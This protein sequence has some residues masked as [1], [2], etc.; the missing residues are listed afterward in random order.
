MTA[1]ADPLTISSNWIQNI[2]IILSFWCLRAE[3]RETSQ[4]ERFTQVDHNSNRWVKLGA[5]AVLLIFYT[6]CE[7]GVV[8]N[9]KRFLH[10]HICCCLI[11][12]TIET[13]IMCNVSHALLLWNDIDMTRQKIKDDNFI[14]F[15]YQKDRFDYNTKVT[16]LCTIWSSLYMCY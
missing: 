2:E 12:E 16:F 9:I 1:I 3:T 10:M 8:Y 5:I 6:R 7:S 14:F 11:C 13:I 15:P 4:K